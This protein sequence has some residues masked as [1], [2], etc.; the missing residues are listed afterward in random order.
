MIT[1][2]SNTLN[3]KEETNNFRAIRRNF[4][5]GQRD[6]FGIYMAIINHERGIGAIRV[7]GSE[8]YDVQFK[9]INVPLYHLMVFDGISK[10]SSIYYV[11]RDAPVM[12]T[13]SIQSE[14]GYHLINTA[15]EPTSMNGE[16][17]LLAEGDYPR[18]TGLEA[19]AVR[20]M[21]H[22]RRLPAVWVDSPDRKGDKNFASEIMIHV[23]GNYTKSSGEKRLA[24]SFGC[25]GVYQGNTTMRAFVADV[26]GRQNLARKHK[27]GT[28]IHLTITQR[29]NVK[30][31]WVLDKK[32]KILR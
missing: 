28:W 20:G 31:S 17:Y 26:V 1:F 21:D 29:P 5:T 3:F 23:G 13:K 6:S 19:F 7:L 10:K 25:F 16:Y 4:A 12:D 2:D 15:F 18:E 24:G 14:S 27:K 22:S 11:T 8:H 9:S 30:W 32:G